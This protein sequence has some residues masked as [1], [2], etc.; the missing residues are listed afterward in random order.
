MSGAAE[1]ADQ[2]ALLQRCERVTGN[3]VLGMKNVEATIGRCSKWR[4]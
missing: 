2:P 1:A 4:M 3:G